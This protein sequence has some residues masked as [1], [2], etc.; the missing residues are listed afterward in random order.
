[1]ASAIV[2]YLA[3]SASVKYVLSLLRYKD[4]PK[5]A[6]LVGTLKGIYIYPV[7]KMKR[8]DLEEAE[9]GYAGLMVDG[10]QDR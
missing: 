1:M 10:Y 3:L 6:Q 7:K 4:R 2:G 9:C 5:E 8:V